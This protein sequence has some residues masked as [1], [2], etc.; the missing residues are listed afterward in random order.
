MNRLLMTFFLG[1]PSFVPRLYLYPCDDVND[2]HNSFTCLL[3][4]IST[5]V[6]FLLRVVSIALYI[7]VVY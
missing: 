2:F 5:S 7:Y 3:F 6:P 1:G 4:D